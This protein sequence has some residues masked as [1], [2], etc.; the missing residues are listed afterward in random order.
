[1]QIIGIIP[2]RYGSTRFP[3]KPLA[4]IKGKPMIQHVYE[5]V[6]KTLQHVVVATDDNRIYDAVKAFKGNVV[7]TNANHKSG[8]DRCAE[9][10][11]MYELETK[12]KFDAAINI[13]GDEPFIEPSQIDQLANLLNK[14]NT[15]L[16]TLIKPIEDK[17]SLFNPNKVKVVTDKN[18][19]ALLFSRQAIPYMRDEN[20]DEWMSSHTYF[21]H[22]G[23]YGYKKETLMQ[24]TKLES[25]SLETCESLEQ[26]RWLENGYSI[27]TDIT[28]IEGKCI[29]T[30]EDLK[31]V[32][33]SLT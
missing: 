22:I 28:H 10:L 25:S 21:Q 30:P 4:D 7:M 23:M 33:K 9:A 31:E 8:T 5:R 26:L 16:A 6:N 14:E 27:N 29:D 20:K 12:L 32:L 1:M 18:G 13:Q 3:G 17:E 19:R 11:Q 24:I 2:A 15:Q